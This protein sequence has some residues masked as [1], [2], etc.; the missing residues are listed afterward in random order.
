MWG[1]LTG[2]PGKMP[3]TLVAYFGT[4]GLLGREGEEH[5][6]FANSAFSANFT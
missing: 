1:I 3:I 6:F 5:E 4:S 2:A